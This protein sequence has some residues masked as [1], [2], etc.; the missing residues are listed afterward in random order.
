MDTIVNKDVFL[1][2]S[3]SIVFGRFN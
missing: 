1:V 3:S 2:G